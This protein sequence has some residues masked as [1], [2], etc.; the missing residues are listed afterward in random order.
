MMDKGQYLLFLIMI[1]DEELA[2]N[3]DLLIDKIN[4][5]IQTDFNALVNILYRMDVSE[6]K[7]KALLKD[8]PG[9]DAA[10][11]IADL[12]IERQAQKIKSRENFKQQ[13]PDTNEELW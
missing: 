11:I 13:P 9:D 10:I 8:H 4:E 12:I 7:L 1:S 3:R 5:L 6:S 2:K